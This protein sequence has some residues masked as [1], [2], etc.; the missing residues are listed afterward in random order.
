MVTI[1]APVSRA[2]A[3]SFA[4]TSRT[5]GKSRSLTTIV[6]SG[7]FCIRAS[8]SSP[9]RPRLRLS[10]SVE[11]AMYCSSRSTNWGTTS[12]PLDEPRLADVGDPAVDDDVRVEDLRA[13]AAG[14]GGRRARGGAAARGRRGRR[15]RRRRPEARRASR[16]PPR[17]APGRRARA[18]P[19][20]ARP[21]PRRGR[22]R[23]PAARGPAAPPP[24]RRAPS[25]PPFR[26]S[27]CASPRRCSPIERRDPRAVILSPG[28][29]S[30]NRRP[31]RGRRRGRLSAD[32]VL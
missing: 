17:R 5:S 10:E 4:S 26:P 15:R 20:R 14:V 31:G 1:R 18:R 6:R 22:D 7:R 12:E 28:G 16:A 8:T 32:A 3:T 27:S 11:S 29:R 30:V 24:P 13:G 25:P 23:A 2:R 19:S 9:R 21:A